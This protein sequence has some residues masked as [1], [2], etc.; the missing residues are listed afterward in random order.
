MLKITSFLNQFDTTVRYKLSLLN[1]KLNKLERSIEYC[2]VIAKNA[3][4]ESKQRK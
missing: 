2:E 3:N 1:E 4:L